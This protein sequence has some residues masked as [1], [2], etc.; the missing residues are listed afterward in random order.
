MKYCQ[1]CGSQMDDDARFCSKCGL[2]HGEVKKETVDVEPVVVEQMDPN[3]TPPMPNAPEPQ[4]YS[5]INEIPP[6]NGM[7]WLILSIV[8]TLCCCNPLQI[9]TIVFSAI[10]L[11]RHKQGEFE[12]A[13]RYSKI[14]MILFFS[15]LALSIIGWIVSF[16]LTGAFVPEF[17]NEFFDQYQYYQ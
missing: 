12:E 7:V 13:K 5:G 4:A 2:E 15:L 9:V 17:F 16:S 14:A 10:S 8:M 11:S 6:N 1:Y 3:G